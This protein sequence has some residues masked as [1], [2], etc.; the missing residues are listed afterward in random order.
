MKKNIILISISFY[1]LFTYG[2]DTTY[3][4]GET[5]VVYFTHLPLVCPYK[6][7]KFCL[8][9]KIFF[10]RLQLLKK[11]RWSIYNDYL[12]SFLFE[13]DSLGKFRPSNRKHKNYNHVENSIKKQYIE[14]VLKHFVWDISMMRK[15]DFH[16][17]DNEFELVLS[18]IINSKREIVKI[19]TFAYGKHDTIHYLLCK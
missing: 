6:E 12:F 4:R 18:I 8:D 1:S 13:T 15:Q 10:Q 16:D 7:E 19:D 3:T 9:T 11:V 14:K 17:E 2:Q 5:E